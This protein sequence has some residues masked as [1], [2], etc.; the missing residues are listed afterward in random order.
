MQGSRECDMRYMNTGTLW[1]VRCDMR[2]ANRLR[3]RYANTLW[4]ARIRYAIREYATRYEQLRSGFLSHH[5]KIS[6][7]WLMHWVAP[8]CLATWSHQVFPH[9]HWVYIINTNCSP[10]HRDWRLKAG[11][12]SV[13]F[14]PDVAKM[15][16]L[17]LEVVGY[18]PLI[19]MA[20]LTAASMSSDTDCS[21]SIESNSITSQP[22]L[23]NWLCFPAL[24]RKRKVDVNRVPL[25]A[26]SGHPAKHSMYPSHGE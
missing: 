7:H 3:A 21:E 18:M 1:A 10:R 12:D 11:L 15:V 6:W 14:E 8:L 26:K 23:L 17:P 20:S 24:C 19:M 16:F 9:F 13:P 2:Y 25:L 5:M 22:S 4:A